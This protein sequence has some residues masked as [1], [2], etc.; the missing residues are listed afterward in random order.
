MNLP[1]TVKII[2]KS[3]QNRVKTLNIRYYFFPKIFKVS[4]NLILNMK[5]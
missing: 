1:R 3:G 5:K 4:E 2:Y